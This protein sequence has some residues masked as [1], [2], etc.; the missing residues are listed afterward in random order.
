MSENVFINDFIS[1][2]MYDYFSKGISSTFESHIIECLC[3]IYDEQQLR[4]IYEAKNDAAFETLLHTYGLQRNVYDNFL[5]DTNKYTRF[6]EENAKDPSVKS[7]IASKIEES[8]I[9]MFLHKCLLIEPT[10]E[11]ITHFEN[12]LLNNF[13]MIKWHFNTSLNPNRTRGIWDKK[14]NFL[15]N[16]VELIEIKPEY[17]DEFT[18]N[19]YGTSLQEVKK[20]DPKMVTEL[21]NYIKDKMKEDSIEDN[22]AMT[23]RPKK[24]S[25]IANSILT[26][27]NG[28]ADAILIASIIA[29]EMS[30]AIIYLF[31]HM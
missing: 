22:G 2:G 6:K 26:T 3:D 20:M 30:I 12:D 14:K 5:R 19:K 21:N 1:T 15:T 16:E 8:L 11:E 31:L 9:T 18:Y 10:A 13:E 27:G 28:F 17:L 23:F 25:G 29:T 7:D 24:K 4:S